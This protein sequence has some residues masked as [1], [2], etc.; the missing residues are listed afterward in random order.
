M[1]TLGAIIVWMFFGLIAGLVARLLV[2]GPQ[3]M[4]WLATMGLGVLGSFAGGFLAYVFGNGEPLQ[5][6]GFILSVVGAIVVL[7]IALSTNRRASI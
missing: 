5:P 6:S 7:L 4:G 2:P 3:K 1:E